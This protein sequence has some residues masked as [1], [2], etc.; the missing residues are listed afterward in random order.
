MNFKL[1]KEIFYIFIFTGIIAFSIN[2]IHPHGYKFISKE[3]NQGEITKNSLVFITSKEGKIK[4]DT[5][6]T[7]FIDSRDAIEFKN[8]SIFNS[9]NIPTFPF[10]ISNKMI[11]KYFKKI[12]SLNEIIIYCNG[13]NCTTS[14]SLAERLIDM[15]YSRHIYI[16]KDGIPKWKEKKYPLAKRN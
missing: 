7:I 6:S 5:G 13:S 14:E 2:L 10:A 1:L 16:L 3:N 12:N 8:E 15:G 9:I 4:F 11:K